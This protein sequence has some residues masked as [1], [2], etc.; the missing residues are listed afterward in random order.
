M[1]SSGPMKIAKF[2][3]KRK[4]TTTTCT[5]K[6]GV[7]RIVPRPWKIVP[8]MPVHDAAPFFSSSKS[9]TTVTMP[10]IQTTS[11][12]RRCQNQ[13]RRRATTSSSRSRWSSVPN[14]VGHGI[15]RRSPRSIAP[16][17]PTTIPRAARIAQP[18][19]SPACRW[20]QTKAAGLVISA[21]A[22]AARRS[23]RHWSASSR[24]ASEPPPGRISVSTSVA[25]GTG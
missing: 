2:A 5:Q 7:E 8:K 19:E 15:S 25:I 3:K 1:I 23:R 18:T 10:R 14:S 4:N 6:P 21:T 12:K 24:L 11:W 9:Q 20:N 17:N 16:R 22:V 13:A